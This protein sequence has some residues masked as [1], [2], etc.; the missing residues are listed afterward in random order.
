MNNLVG[1]N[2]RRLRL[3]RGLTQEKLGQRCGGRSVNQINGYE[4]GR[5]RP[6]P[7]LLAI[8]AKALDVSVDEL[9]SPLH[10]GAEAT[11]RELIM[12]LKARLARDIGVLPGSVRLSIEIVN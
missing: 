2:I 10:G 11:A 12:E 9:T 6:S 3:E 8:L 1:D 4:R 7:R 5:S